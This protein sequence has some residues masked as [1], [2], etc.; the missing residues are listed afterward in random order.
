MISMYPAC[1]YK[2]KDG[3]Y[4]VFPVLDIATCGY[5]EQDAKIMAVDCLA[6]YL[7]DANVNNKHV[8]HAPVVEDIDL[9]SVANHDNVEYESAFIMQVC[10]DAEKYA[11]KHFKL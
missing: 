3:Y 2:T 1:F 4:V 8:P 10:I 5:N 9:K 7:Y 11:K 6:N